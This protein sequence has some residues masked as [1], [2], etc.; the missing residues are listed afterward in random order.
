MNLAAFCLAAPVLGAAWMRNR[1]PHEKREPT[2]VLDKLVPAT[3]LMVIGAVVV[4]LALY[5]TV[6][7]DPALYRA[8]LAVVLLVIVI[9]WAWSRRRTR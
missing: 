9:G 4:G 6:G 2:W 7:R 8:A 5:P 3:I 1:Y